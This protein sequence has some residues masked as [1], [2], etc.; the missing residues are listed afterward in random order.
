MNSFFGSENRRA[1]YLVVASL[2]L[3]AVFRVVRAAALPELPNFFPVTALAFCGGFFLSGMSAW[4]LPL[5]VLF[6]SDIALAMVMGYP[7]FGGGQLAAWG[8]L[9]LVVAIGR[10]AASRGGFSLVGCFGGLLGG[11]VVFYL[12]TNTAAWLANPAYPRGL[13]GL[14]MSL[15]TGLPGYPPTWMFFRNS[16]A[17]DFLFT[18]LLIGVCLLAGGLSGKRDN[19]S[20]AA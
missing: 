16:V 19:L 11:G 7:V 12:I 10:I 4:I 14:W 8:S 6:A 18:G 2:V 15:T 20:E 17:A 5:A 3:L 1:V 9:V 13:G